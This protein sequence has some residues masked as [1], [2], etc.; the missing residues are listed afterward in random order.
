M[1]SQSKTETTAEYEA[2]A[3]LMNDRYTCRSFS[4]DPVP[5]EQIRRLLRLAQRTASWSN[6]Q[7]WDLI[8]TKDDGTE[9][10]RA[11]L[12]EAAKTQEVNSD[13]PQPEEYRGIYRD[14]RRESGYALYA[15]VLIEKSDSA[16]RETQRL[17]NYRLFG[18]PHF[19]LVHSDVKIG[20]YGWVDCGGYIATFLLAAQSL[21]I[22]AA[23]QAAIAMQSRFVHEYFNLPDDR[24]VIAG[25]S[26]GYAT[27]HP[28]NAFRTTRADIDDVVNWVDR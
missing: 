28:I 9:R 6:V 13:I 16:A 2:I 20:P 24:V 26:F 14:R 21:G 4:S 12:Y 10:F 25:I 15:S 11:A 19:L 22:A 3:Q 1:T 23:P 7:P 18:A 8:L 17:E 5:E 27:D